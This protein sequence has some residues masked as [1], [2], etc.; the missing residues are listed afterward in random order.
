MSTE[1]SNATFSC[2]L[3]AWQAHE[4]ELS[5]YLMHRLGDRHLADDLLQEILL[6]VMRQEK[7]FCA[8]TQKRAW[9]FQVARNLLVDRARLQKSEVEVDADL[10]Q[11]EDER[12]PVEA[13]DTC[14]ARNLAELAPEDS[15]IIEQCDLL[16]IK[17]RDFADARGLS[18][19]AVKSRLLRARQRLRDNLVRNCQVRFDA[20]GQ[21]CCHVPRDTPTR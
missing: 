3:H 2:V 14:L 7:G 21:V 20:A 1:S 11:H 18:L 5:G 15:E 10:P 17:Q 6:K 8:I 19:A 13:L 9:L 4:K 12:A 16:G